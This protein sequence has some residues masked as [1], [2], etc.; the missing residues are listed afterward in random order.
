MLR[1][2][3]LT[4]SW[5]DSEAYGRSSLFRLIKGVG[6][7]AH[8]VIAC[9]DIEGLAGLIKGGDNDVYVVD[10]A[11]A[12][13]LDL[14]DEEEEAMERASDIEDDRDERPRGRGRGRR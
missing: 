2:L 5:P 9:E 7:G 11:G 13:W 3:A 14:G 12:L 1:N 6:V 10:K 4:R 8:E